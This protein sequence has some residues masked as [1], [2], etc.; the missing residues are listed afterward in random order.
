ME[1]ILKVEHLIELRADNKNNVSI[2]NIRTSL[3]K[4]E[5]GDVKCK[6]VW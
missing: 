6:R 5:L 3:N 1:L 2:S 4:M